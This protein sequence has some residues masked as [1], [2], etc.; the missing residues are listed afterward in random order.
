MSTFS[1]PPPS[2]SSS[3]PRPI[4]VPSPLCLLC[5]S[6][7]LPSTSSSSSSSPRPILTSCCQRTICVSCQ[8]N[9]R[10]ARWDPCLACEGGWKTAGRKSERGKER[11]CE[12]VLGDDD[13]DDEEEDEED[14]GNDEIEIE[15]KEKDDK[16]PLTQTNSTSS[17]PT[18]PK[19]SP[20]SSSSSSVHHLLLPSD[21]LLGLSLR[22][23]LDPHHICTLNNL[24]FSTIHTTPHLLH[25]RTYL[26]LLPSPPPPLPASVQ[27][28]RDHDRALARFA[29]V[30]KEQD[31][32]IR[33]AYVELAEEGL[34]DREEAAGEG[35]YEEGEKEKKGGKGVAGER[36]TEG[37]A[38]GRFFEDAEWERE[39]SSGGGGRLRGFPVAAGNSGSGW[40]SAGSSAV[41]SVDRKG[42]GTGGGGGNW[43]SGWGGK[44]GGKEVKREVVGKV[45]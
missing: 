8:I 25:T 2:S 21:T 29:R 39:N 18:D 15:Q 41:G 35:G 14:E 30:T 9:K 17:A 24:P 43:W 13:D 31:P 28:Q 26:L 6:S 3:T 4:H 22:Y 33:K 40:R 32:L 16:D 1:L 12:F 37:R 42:A 11:E 5:S 38:V 34:L 45:G 19:P 36:T 27:A 20:C 23:S 7:I 44:S 10:I